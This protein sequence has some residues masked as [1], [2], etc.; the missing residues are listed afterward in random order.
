M[1]WGTRTWRKDKA[2][3]RQPPDSAARRRLEPPDDALLAHRRDQ[4]RHLRPAIEA[5]QR[6]AERMEQL[7]ALLSCPV[8]ELR[9][10]LAPRLRGPVEPLRDRRCFLD[11]QPFVMAELRR[12]H[13]AVEYGKP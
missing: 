11:Q 2:A 5:G 12:V 9:R 3:S 6:Q 7:A 4:R 1:A 13:I 8:L 10:Q